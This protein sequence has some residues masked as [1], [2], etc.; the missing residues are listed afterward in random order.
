MLDM[1]SETESN[2][3]KDV[4][5][6]KLRPSHACQLPMDDRHEHMLHIRKI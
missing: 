2:I 1:G 3:A 4:I 5:H 6:P